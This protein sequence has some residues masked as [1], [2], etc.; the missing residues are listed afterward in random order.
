MNKLLK[1]KVAMLML[2]ASIIAMTPLDAN[3]M[4]SV[5]VP[6]I[7]KEKNV[8]TGNSNNTYTNPAA[9]VPQDET[10][11]S[12]QAG[13]ETTSEE[14]AV[15]AETEQTEETP[16]FGIPQQQTTSGQMY[17]NEPLDNSVPVIY[18]YEV[19]GDGYITPGEEFKLK[20]MVY[21]P[22][23]VSK[24]G[25]ISVVV[26]QDENLVYPT[27]KGTNSV[28]LGYLTTLSYAEGELKLMASKDISEDEIVVN[29]TLKYSDN[30]ARDNTQKFTAVLPVSSSGKLK[31]D[32]V[33]MPT[34]PHVG[35]NNR[36]KVAYSNNSLSVINDLTLHLEAADME[37]QTVNLGT[38][39]SG[40]SLTSDV[41][42]EFA[43]VGEQN[44]NLKFTYT[45]QSGQEYETD[46]MSYTL[47]VEDYDDSDQQAEMAYNAR[48]NIMNRVVTVIVLI[49]CLMVLG[50]NGK[51]Y[52]NK[53]NTGNKRKS[54]NKKVK[55]K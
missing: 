31:I 54:V 22:A 53:K 3:A 50:V 5:T 26:T 52:L 24:L 51:K 10:A 36:I 17:V 25:N 46:V 2:L 30:Y 33:E 55:V 37:E 34:S 21:N 44:A 29:L 39:G 4:Q 16:E 43:T 48:R 15:D 13:P 12:E 7:F 19:E 49:G 41:Y 35:G 11:T 27:Y 32:N 28:Y 45:D 23:V 9:N 6:N 47:N 18:K 1:N 42:A 38:I 20:F 8:N 40:S 14:T